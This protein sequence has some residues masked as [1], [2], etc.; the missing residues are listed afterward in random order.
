V[1]KPGRRHTPIRKLIYYVAFVA[2]AL[3]AVAAVAGEDI[4]MRAQ[5]GAVLKPSQ[6][7]KLSIRKTCGD[8]H[9]VDAQA[10]SLHFNRSVAKPDPE[11]ADCLSCHLPKTN[12]FTT[13]GKIAKTVAIPTPAN[14]AQ[15]H[16]DAAD[17]IAAGFHGRPD[18]HPGDHPTC[19]R[20]HSGNPH[21]IEP[22]G[23]KS[24]K[25]EAELCSSCHRRA[26]LM[27]RY[28]KSPEAVPSYEQSFHGKALLRF[29]KED[30]AA[31]IDCHG[32][33]EL[34]SPTTCSSPQM[35]KMCSKCHPGAK[36]N[37]CMSGANHLRLKMER[38][39]AL[40]AEDFLFK[41]LTL[42]VMLLLV[43][44][45]ALDLRR[46]VFGANFAP[47]SGRMVAVLVAASFCAMIAGFAMA[48]GRLAGSEWAWAAGLA[49]M[50]AAF[51]VWF[52]RKKP[53]R[54][55]ERLYHRF[56]PAQRAQHIC[57]VASFVVL[58]LT[59]MPLKFAH[60]GWSHHL[61][62]LFG[63]FAGARIAHRIAGIVMTATWLWH[64]IYLLYLW[65]KAA[66]SLHSWTMW[67]G[68]KDFLDFFDTIR[69]YAGLRKDP[70][71]YARFNWKEK[72]D[73]FAVYW[74]MPIMVLSG[75]VLWFPVF[76]GNRLTDLGLGVAYIAHSDEALLAF[77]AIL[78]WHLYNTHF[79]PEHFPMS[80]VW[81]SG[82]LT[83]SEMEREHPLEKAK[84][85]ATRPGVRESE[86]ATEPVPDA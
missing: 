36:M 38:S 75:L 8:C 31:C 9:D 15:C 51:A 29:G 53:P 86:A 45:V 48:V 42:G 23:R 41:A 47:R 17:V 50:A 76:F 35:V 19:V 73:Y 33:H 27:G 62:I 30:A 16:S 77:L 58:V 61:H 60:V 65:R 37:F 44:V 32:Y 55:K 2:V 11:A 3:R 66:F 83:E 24:T 46:K 13:D 10:K 81:L 1:N 69:H 12:P 39:F 78:M 56:S 71:Q 21:D 85:D 4:T 67:P 49:L 5:S 28:G 57:L 25:S 14:C 20:C 59:G 70:P 84:L 72:F 22:I 80:S 26:D 40:R 6:I 79:D 74:G 34:V 18:K 63:G 52:A 64:G 68:K 54:K 43:G 82:A 7:D